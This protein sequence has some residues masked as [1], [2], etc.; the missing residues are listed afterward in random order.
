MIPRLQLMTAS[1]RE[2]GCFSVMK[3]K[4]LEEEDGRPFAVAVERTFENLRTVIGNGLVLCTRDFYHKGGY[5]TFE[6]QVEGHDRVLFHRGAI[7]DHS[8][9]CVVV[10]ESF[11]GLD[12]ATKQYS[13]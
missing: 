12:K 3:W 7:E 1:K 4:T 9:A 6:I 10:G 13:G 11:G 8:L 5:E 2:D